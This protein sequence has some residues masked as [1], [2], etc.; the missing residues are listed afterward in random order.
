MSTNLVKHVPNTV[1][2]VPDYQHNWKSNAKKAK[3]SEHNHAS[4]FELSGSFISEVGGK[5]Q[6]EPRD[7]NEEQREE[8]LLDLC[9][10]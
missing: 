9:G 5:R 3:D 8:N 10:K 2:E 6:V 4:G 7:G 1:Q